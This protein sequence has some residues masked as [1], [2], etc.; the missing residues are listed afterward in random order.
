MEWKGRVQSRIDATKLR[1][2]IGEA[3]SDPSLAQTDDALK[4][5]RLVDDIANLFAQLSDL[6]V[7]LDLDLGPLY[8]PLHRPLTLF[9]DLPPDDLKPADQKKLS[10]YG[11]TMRALVD[12]GETIGV[13]Y[14]E[15]Y[16]YVPTPGPRNHIDY[17]RGNAIHMWSALDGTIET[18]DF[19]ELGLIEEHTSYRC[20]PKLPLRHVKQGERVLFEIV[21]RGLGP[22]ERL[23]FHLSRDGT[24]FSSAIF[25]I[26]GRDDGMVKAYHHWLDPTVLSEPAYLRIDYHHCESVRPSAST[27]ILW[28]LFHYVNKPLR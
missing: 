20:K 2:W 6:G 7:A 24:S 22:T 8:P 19:K 15:G 14:T 1:T 25:T 12:G 27:N 21:M 3:R 26:T 18:Q 11:D 13:R 9:P 17:R 10:A 28:A 5:Y 16:G 4:R 23:S